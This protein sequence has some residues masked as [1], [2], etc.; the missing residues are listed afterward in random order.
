MALYNGAPTTKGFIDFVETSAVGVLGLVPT[1]VKNW[2][3]KKLIK[4]NSWINVK[5]FSSTGEVSNAEDMAYLMKT[6]GETYHRILWWYGDWRGVYLK[7]HN[8]RE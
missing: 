3:N 4:P 5:R 2:R 1:L 6:T 8:G 7:Y